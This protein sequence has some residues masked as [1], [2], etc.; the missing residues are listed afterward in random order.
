[1]RKLAYSAPLLLAK[2]VT[3]SLKITVSKESKASA[4]LRFSNKLIR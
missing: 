3:S 1:M 2:I 4:I